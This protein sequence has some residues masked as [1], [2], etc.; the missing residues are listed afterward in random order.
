M[1]RIIQPAFLLTA[2]LFLNSCGPSQ[3]DL[4]ALAPTETF[5]EDTFLKTA[6]PKKA[7]VV[8]AHDDDLVAMS[9][10]LAKLNAAGWEIKQLCFVSESTERDAAL[11]QAANLILDEVE[12]IKIAPEKRRNDL[13]STTNP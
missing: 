3:D 1:K 5:P 8:V 11:V 13:D 6:T 12:F 9:G 4:K 7:L 10:T 2:C